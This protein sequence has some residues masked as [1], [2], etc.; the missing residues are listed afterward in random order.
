MARPS[1]RPHVLAA[2]PAALPA[3]RAGDSGFVVIL[4]GQAYAS[5]S[6]RGRPCN[7]PPPDGILVPTF[8]ALYLANT[9][10]F[11]FLAIR[12]ISNE[13]QTGSL[14]L[15]LQLPCSIGTVVGQN[16]GAGDRVA[17][18]GSPNLTAALWVFA[19]ATWTQASS[20]LS[21]AISSMARSSPVLPLLPRRS[22]NRARRP[23]F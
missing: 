17:T 3:R 15:L 10:L 9:F 22:R 20:P 19:G 2:A 14:K 18:Y 5:Q 12:T 4:Y 21:F 16:W 8:G 13:K 7:P 6:A 1:C 23:Q 11:P